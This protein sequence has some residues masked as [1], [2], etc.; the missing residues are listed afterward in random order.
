MEETRGIVARVSADLRVVCNRVA[1]SGR[2]LWWSSVGAPFVCVCVRVR[3]RVCAR[4]CVNM[5]VLACAC[6]GVRVRAC[7]YVC[8]YVCVR[9]SQTCRLGEA[10]SSP[11]PRALPAPLLRTTAE[12]VRCC[13]IVCVLL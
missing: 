9:P 4:P 5:G 13:A 11:H 12:L 10:A 2:D 8:V 1:V 6:A 3:V 7:A